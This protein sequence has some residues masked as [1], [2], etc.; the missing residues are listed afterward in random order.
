MPEGPR[1]EEVEQMSTSTAEERGRGGRRGSRIRG[2][3]ETVEDGEGSCLGGEEGR[4]GSE[5][6]YVGGV[7]EEGRGCGRIE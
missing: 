1:P 7:D 5:V 3:S 4:R 6:D 2:T